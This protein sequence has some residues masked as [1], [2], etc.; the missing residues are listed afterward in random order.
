M[1]DIAISI[2]VVFLGLCLGSFA[3][4]LVYRIP[5]DIPWVYDSAKSSKNK[6]ARSA[7]PSC[8][9]T[10]GVFDL[11]PIFSWLLLRGRCRYCKNPVSGLY[12][13][14]ETMT[15]LAVLGLFW[16]WGLH[17][18]SVV[19]FVA[20][21][22]LVAALVIDWEY[23]ILP[24]VLNVILGILGF[25]YVLC[26]W[27]SARWDAAVPIDHTLAAAVLVGLFVAAA[28]IVSWIKK[29]PALGW[30]D[31]KFLGPAG[32]FL[33]FSALPSFMVI[34]GLCALLTAFLR[35]GAEQGRFPFGP[36]L[37]ISLYIHLFLTG[38]GFDYTW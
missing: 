29:Q 12:P 20:V 6:A 38:L 25:A 19:L 15:M 28:F 3:T 16:V 22:F 7:C 35:T 30:G 36:A 9:H 1:T 34:G 17:P 13:L 5:R 11:V 4:A 8:G 23:M 33:G 31:I 21:P 37:I 2:A 10:L 24:D 18:E 32:L 27:R 26:L 14:V